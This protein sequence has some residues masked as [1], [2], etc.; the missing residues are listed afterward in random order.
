MKFTIYKNIHEDLVTGKWRNNRT[1]S[2]PW[3]E[4]SIRYG[5]RAV[6]QR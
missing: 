4:F 2:W 3:W 6:K 1:L 5:M